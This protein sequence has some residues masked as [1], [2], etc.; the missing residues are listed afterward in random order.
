MFPFY[1]SWKHLKTSGFLIFSVSINW[2]HCAGM[3][4]SSHRRC[5][6]KISVLRNFSK[7]TGKH[8]CQRLFFNKVA[9]LGPPTL[10]KKSLWHRCFPVNFAK[11]L[12]TTFLQ[13]T[14]GQLL[15]NVLLTYLAMVRMNIEEFISFFCSEF[16]SS[17]NQTKRSSRPEVFCKKDVLRNFAKFTGKHLP[18]Y[19][20]EFKLK[21]D[22]KLFALLIHEHKLKKAMVCFLNFNVRTVSHFI[23]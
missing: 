22:G 21:P 15:L 8:L 2:E 14:S 11:F 13:N 10:L 1:T 9:G 18:S 7:F 12:R 5:S 6:V 17:A 20:K 23:E 4:R 19:L 16:F 3:G